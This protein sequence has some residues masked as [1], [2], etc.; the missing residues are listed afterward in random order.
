[1]LT[2]E[3]RALVIDLQDKMLD[4]V[5]ERREAR[6]S[7]NVGDVE[8]LDGEIEALRAECDKIRQS[9]ENQR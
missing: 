4:L 1:M 6:A 2:E 3:E 9:A 5:E 7:G 8:K